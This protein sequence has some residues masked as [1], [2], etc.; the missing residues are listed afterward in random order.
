M[1]SSIPYLGCIFGLA[2][3]AVGIYGIVLNVRAVKVAHH[4]TTGRAV[5][6]VLV[7]AALLLVII[8]CVVIVILALLGP[9]IGNIFEDIVL[10]I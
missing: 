2:S 7:P 8:P 1:L 4:M 5:A 9:A 3:L 6:A 10:S